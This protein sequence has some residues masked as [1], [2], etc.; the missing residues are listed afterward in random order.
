MLLMLLPPDYLH[1]E[2]GMSDLRTTA[3]YLLT[4]AAARILRQTLKLGH[5]VRQRT[6]SAKYW[7]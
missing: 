2:A 1:R 4:D 7:A 6:D 3:F 5:N